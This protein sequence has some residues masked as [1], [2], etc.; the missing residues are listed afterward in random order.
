MQEE[1]CVGSSAVIA[2]ERDTQ[3]RL[4]K[5]KVCNLQL[6]KVGGTDASHSGF[7]SKVTPKKPGAD[8][9]VLR[10]GM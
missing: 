5:T 9:V 6:S 1:V 8:T 10:Q 2:K 4:M 7:R 3:T